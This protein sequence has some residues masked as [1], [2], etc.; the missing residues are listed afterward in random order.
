MRKEL[1][2]TIKRTIT[3]K[4]IC[5]KFI[6]LWISEITCLFSKQSL[7]KKCSRFNLQFHSPIFAY[8]IVVLIH[9]V[10]N[11]DALTDSRVHSLKLL[12]NGIHYLKE[13][14]QNRF[15]KNQIIRKLVIFFFL[16][17]HGCIK[18]CLVGFIG[19][20]HFGRSWK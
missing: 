16:I 13:L 11:F 19:K 2:W 18:A 1:W 17:K 6:I 3:I 5:W 9:A 4:E 12:R 7:K 8:K 10:N 20:C 14:L 15:P